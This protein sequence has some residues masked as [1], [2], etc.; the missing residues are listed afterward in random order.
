MPV[1]LSSVYFC[2][3]D[4][5]VYSA[6]SSRLSVMRTSIAYS[7]CDSHTDRPASSMLL[8][9]M[10]APPAPA[11]SASARWSTLDA[12]RPRRNE[13][14]RPNVLIHPL[15]AGRSVVD[16]DGDVPGACCASPSLWLTMERRR[17]GM[18]HD[19][20]LRRVG[21]SC[22]ASSGSSLISPSDSPPEGYD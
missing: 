17:F 4:S 14:R 5:D 9:P 6:V 16:V 7:S 2:S 18:Y 15:Y 20:V 13:P 21:G 12:R 22:A 1:R 10:L 8:P 11:S 19:G 3:S